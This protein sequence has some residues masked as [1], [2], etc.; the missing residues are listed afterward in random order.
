MSNRKGWFDD[1][2]KR[3]LRRYFDGDQWTDQV[4]TASGE[5][6]S[7]PIEPTA[8]SLKS[9]ESWWKKKLGG[10]VPVWA[11][12]LAAFILIG[13]IGNAFEES[14]TE[15]ESN[16]TG[17]ES[18]SAETV[19]E[20][21]APEEPSVATTAGSRTTIAPTTTAAP[22]TTDSLSTQSES[23]SSSISSAG[24]TPVED[25]EGIFYLETLWALTVEE[26]QPRSGYDRDDWPHWKDTNGSGCDSR[27]DL[28]M[29][30][31]FENPVIDYDSCS[32]SGGVWYSWY[33]GTTTTNSSSFDV[34]HIVSLAEAHD[35]GGANWS[36]SKKQEFANYEVNLVLVS[37]SSNRSKSDK[38]VAEWKPAQQ[39][40]C[41]TATRIVSV[42]YSFGLS[43]D[44]AEADA[45]EEMLGYCGSEGQVD[46][47]VANP[48][49]P[50]T[51]PATTATT[52]TTAAPATTVYYQN[53]DAVRAAGAAPIYVGDPGYR[54]GL[55]RDGDGVGCE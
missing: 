28:V 38:D 24:N 37:A 41:A 8:V 14:P 48:A 54:P 32:V 5:V 46:W 36:R 22:T 49:I 23:S 21:D 16:P 20:E 39:A 50:E 51:A 33:D 34:D 13:A 52:A 2:Y 3:H 15:Q 7:D 19:P 18:R 53:C 42:K 11:A 40:W 27:E 30:Y 31:A 17:Q 44:Q 10:K 9:G 45:L 29:L 12:I 25:S 55:D 26:E 43:V 6:M 47:F 4:Q 1:P 35:S